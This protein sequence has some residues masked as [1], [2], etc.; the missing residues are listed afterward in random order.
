MEDQA[1]KE[2]FTKPIIRWGMITLLGSIPFCF[3]P[4]LYLQL[5][6]MPSLRFTQF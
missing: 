3:G 4:A 5:F 6:I 2:I 1:Y